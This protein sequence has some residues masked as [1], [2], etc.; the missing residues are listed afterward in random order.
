MI[1]CLQKS[2][3]I[4]IKKGGKKNRKVN[5]TVYLLG[6]VERICIQ[7]L[8]NIVYEDRNGV[9]KFLLNNTDKNDVRNA[10]EREKN[11]EEKSA[12]RAAQ[13]KI[14]N[15]KMEDFKKYGPFVGAINSKPNPGIQSHPIPLNEE[16]KQYYKAAAKRGGA[17]QKTYSA[18]IDAAKKIRIKKKISIK[19]TKKAPP[20]DS[21]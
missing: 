21:E 9:E 17:L 10:S 12:G 14:T 15:D 1:L 13:T 19:S 11:A 16:A 20:S 3:L 6:H 8:G 2:E 5:L 7:Q 4:P 18:T